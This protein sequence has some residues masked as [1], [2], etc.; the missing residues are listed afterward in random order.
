MIERKKNHTKNLFLFAIAC[1]IAFVSNSAELNCAD[2][3][4]KNMLI[5]YMLEKTDSWGIFTKNRSNIMWELESKH[6][7]YFFYDDELSSSRD[8]LEKI[9]LKCK[10]KY[11]FSDEV[12]RNFDWQYNDICNGPYFF[13]RI[14]GV[15]KHMKNPSIEFQ[16]SNLYKWLIKN[17]MGEFLEYEG[18]WKKQILLRNK[19]S[20]EFEKEINDSIKNP[21]LTKIYVTDIRT[22]FYD[23]KIRNIGCKANVVYQNNFFGKQLMEVEYTI[24]TTSDN[25]P[26]FTLQR[27]VYE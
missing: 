5:N 7:G 25:K 16:N 18:L 11:R 23:K 26:Y 24:E 21:S 2:T 4:T 10:E 8:E 27:L 19:I 13:T 20:S 14:D 15:N 9:F 17:L 1:S 3:T 12:S 22:S 6:P